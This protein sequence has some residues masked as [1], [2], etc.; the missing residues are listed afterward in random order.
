MSLMGCASISNTH[1]TIQ[2]GEHDAGEASKLAASIRERSSAPLVS[3][4][5]EPIVATTPIK[6]SFVSKS[7]PALTCLI[8]FAPV[9]PMD[10]LE[11]AQSV[12]KLCGVTVRVTP[13]ALTALTPSNSST[14]SSAQKPGTGT[15]MIVPSIPG[16]PFIPPPIAL[17]RPVQGLI[18]D[19]KWANR[20]LEGLLD[21]VTA[22][23]GL[24]WKVE[25]HTITIFHVESR[26]FAIHAIPSVTDIQSIV[27]S[28]T[29][30]ASGV[31]G[32]G[33]GGVSGNSGSSQT[34]S[35]SSKT[36]MSDDL[37]K[38]LRSM[39]TPNLGRMAMSPSTGTVA[40]TDT[41]ETLRRIERY[42]EEE[43]AHLTKNVL[44]NV[45]VLAVTLSNKDS[46]GIDWNLVYK[47]ASGKFGATL[48]NAFH[49]SA[50]AVSGSINILKPATGTGGV[51]AGTDLLIQALSQQ[52]SV[53]N[54]TSSST[55]T[56]NLQ[57]SPV[58]VGQ[59]TSYLQS[60]TT[61]ATAQ[62]GTSTTLTPGTITTG[63]NMNL[64]PYVMN[65]KQVL[66]QY[67][68]NLSALRRIRQ[69]KSGDNMIEIPEVDNRIF[70][71]K[72]R[73]KSG[74]TLVLSG[75]EQSMGIGSA[76]GVGSAWNPVLGGEMNSER[77]R[78]V[79][80]I[81]INPVVQDRH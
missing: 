44:L 41:P 27:Q 66:L 7:H 43:N 2:Q 9:M 78:D 21:V 40:I 13:D 68:I 50:D 1:K 10:V 34:T 12:S 75:F 69:V 56:M 53:S 79:I 59:Q 72:V 18:T 28:G 61:T 76:S 42:L 81:L 48:N 73:L 65:N 26:T 49:A 6:R 70:S 19:I 3:F 20:P 24:S 30:T 17:P 67:S 36:S 60:V 31:S 11:F 22:R 35:V 55:T 39:L 14:S 16:A 52:G 64:L 4:S 54:I 80:V 74:E 33:A 71:Q 25:D 45:K 38:M 63:F 51:F 29:T 77:R 15:D 23:L 32:G 5:N 58:Q 47:T 8:T 57:P 46:F 37:D 62:V